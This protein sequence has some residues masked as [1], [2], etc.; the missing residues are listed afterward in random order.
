VSGDSGVGPGDPDRLP[1]PAVRTIGPIPPG[2][3]RVVLIRHGEA[4]CNVEGIVGGERGCTG[5]S[6]RG[7]SQVTALAERLALSGELVGV[8]ALFASVLPRALETARIIA[9]ALERWR[10]GPP[11]EV[12]ADCTLC[13][14]HP[15]EADGLT[16][17][18][19]A[20]RFSAPDWDVDPDQELAP[21]AESWTGFVD[22][23]AAAVTDLADSHRGQLVVVACHAGVVEATMLRFLPLAPR[24][25]RLGLRTEHASMTE[26]ER[27]GDRWLL[28]RYN[29]TTPVWVA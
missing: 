28:R 19:F 7:L 29:D 5:L 17:P 10:S 15:G 11:L 22:R 21:G 13:E 1:P 24:T 23:A 25:T 14:L 16:W 27:S 2:A 9:P 6:A 8:G 20:S 4:V 3:T 26:W 12:E 18:E